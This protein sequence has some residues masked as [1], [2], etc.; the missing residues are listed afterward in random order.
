MKTE[1]INWTAVSSIA[2]IITLCVSLV[3]NGIDIENSVKA[4]RAQ[5]FATELQVLTSAHQMTNGNLLRDLE[6]IDL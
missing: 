6:G 3:Y 5:R 4:S 1:G 2:A